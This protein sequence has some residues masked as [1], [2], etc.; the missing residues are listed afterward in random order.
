MVKVRAGKAGCPPIAAINGV[1]ML[2]TSELTICE[3]RADHD[4]D[5][6]VDDVTTQNKGETRPANHNA[7]FQRGGMTPMGCARTAQPLCVLTPTGYDPWPVG[8]TPHSTS[9]MSVERS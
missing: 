6:Q 9:S 8:Q 7:L 3:R 4:G 2:A 5:G 1:M